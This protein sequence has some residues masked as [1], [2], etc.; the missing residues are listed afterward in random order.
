[1]QRVKDM[2]PISILLIILTTLI[3]VVIDNYVELPWISFQTFTNTITVISSILLVAIALKLY[4]KFS[5][6]QTIIDK[7]TALVIEVVGLLSEAKFG[8]KVVH[9]NHKEGNALVNITIHGYKSHIARNYK[10]IPEKDYA[11]KNMYIDSDIFHFLEQLWK[12]K[13]NPYLPKHIAISLRNDFGMS[14]QATFKKNELNEEYLEFGTS[15]RNG[16]DSLLWQPANVKD[17]MKNMKDIYDV[18]NDWL[19][20][21]NPEVYD[22]LNLISDRMPNIRD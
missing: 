9:K 10:L 12:L 7:Q 21:N 16:S 19:K 17:I 18:C 20:H 6:A 1:M 4:K 5:G 2:L 3:A 15:M 8:L 14:A 13:Y 22:S 11:D